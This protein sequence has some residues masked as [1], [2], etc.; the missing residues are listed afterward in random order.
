[1]TLI[2]LIPF[3]ASAGIANHFVDFFYHEQISSRHCGK[4]I[5]D[6]M[7]YLNQKG[8]SLQ[9]FS[10]I[11]ITAPHHIWSFGNVVALNSRWG[12]EKEGIL[13]ENW[14]FHVIAVHRGK[15]YDFS[16][17]Q[18]PLILPLRMYMQ[19]MFIPKKS[20]AINGDTFRV[21]GKGPI[22]TAQDALEELQH[23]RFKILLT[24]SSGVFKEIENEVSYSNF[25][26]R[27]GAV[28]GL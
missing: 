22:Y 16:F 2:I 10:I 20:F 6:F 13:H 9:D 15:V 24:D 11:T 25:M 23:Y 17:N 8:E 12:T 1:M 26:K 27:Y 18:T 14:A 5:S 4:N 7:K 21:R 3:Y 28:S 19:K